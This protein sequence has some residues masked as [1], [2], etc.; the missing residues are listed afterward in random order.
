LRGDAS[1]LQNDPE[2]LAK[3]HEGAARFSAHPVHPP[4]SFCGRSANV[5]L[6]VGPIGPNIGA[7]SRNPRRRL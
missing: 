5:G 6:W 2:L 4:G 3:G 1:H 7:S